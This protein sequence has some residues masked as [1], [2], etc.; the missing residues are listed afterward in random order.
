MKRQAVTILA[1]VFVWGSFAFAQTFEEE[2]RDVRR[3]NRASQQQ[4][5][6]SAQTFD[7]TFVNH[8]QAGMAAEQDVHLEHEGVAGVFR[9]TAE[10][11]DMT[12]LLYASAQGKL[13]DP[14][15]PD[16]VGPFPKGVPLGVTLGDWL[17]ASGEATI[18]CSGESA[19]VSA[20]FSDLIPNGVYTLWYS[21]LAL[22]PTSPLTVM[23]LPLGARDGSQNAVLADENGNA[24]YT[25]ESAPCLQPST[26]Q[27]GSMLAL[28]YHSDG[29]TYG[30]DPGQ[31]GYNAH[32]QLFALLPTT[33]DLAGN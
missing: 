23:N 22:P 21:F 8:L 30:L 3:A 17:A 6:A 7:L 28:N 27:V 2:M 19:T 4:S 13:H 14:T 12:A 1:L 5:R 20:T 24:V 9:A 31:F 32:I 11:T 29:R 18:T 33:A 25:L 16:A 26:A 15:N 10:D